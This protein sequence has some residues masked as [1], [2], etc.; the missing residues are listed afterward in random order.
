[1]RPRLTFVLAVAAFGLIS[2]KGFERWPR[3]PWDAMAPVTAAAQDSQTPAATEA[4]D[5]G[6][7]RPTSEQ[8]LLERLG[9]RRQEI[10]AQEQALTMREKLLEA[11]EKRV[12]ER[13]AELKAIEERFAA[14]KKARQEER[15]QALQNVVTM[16]EGMKPKDA[17]RIFNDLDP[18]V[19]LSVVKQ[20]NARKM[21]EVLAQMQPAAAQRLTVELA[22]E[23]QVPEPVAE[24]GGELPKIGAP[25]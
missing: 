12:E 6:A 14:E 18:E 1:M 17:A 8:A 4:P 13:L 11:T 3:A 20:M 22:R 16:Y 15:V 7:G 10:E 5:Q 24:V 25:D 23:A 9:E 19:L 21:A 2:A